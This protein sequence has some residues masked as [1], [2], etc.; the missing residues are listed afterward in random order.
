MLNHLRPTLVALMVCDCF[1]NADVILSPLVIK[2]INKAMK[3]IIRYRQD[4]RTEKMGCCEFASQE[5]N[6]RTRSCLTP[7]FVNFGYLKVAVLDFF[8]Y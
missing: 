5:Q 8:F 1:T 6:D 7:G 3:P 2:R 4:I